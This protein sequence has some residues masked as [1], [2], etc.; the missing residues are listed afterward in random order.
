MTW[1]RAFPGPKG[2]RL[3]RNN[4]SPIWRKACVTEEA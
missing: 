2:G 4:F 1:A 3:R